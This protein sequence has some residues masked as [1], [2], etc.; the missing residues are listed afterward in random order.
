MIIVTMIHKKQTT[1]AKKIAWS[2]FIEA[3]DREK[4][5]TTVRRRF[6]LRMMDF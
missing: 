2:V 4:F 5:A 6:A 1:R 3:A